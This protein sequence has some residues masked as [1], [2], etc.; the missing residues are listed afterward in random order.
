MRYTCSSFEIAVGPCL[1]TI[2]NNSGTGFPTCFLP[3]E[4][5][6]T[7]ASSGQPCCGSGWRQPRRWVAQPLAKSSRHT[8]AQILLHQQQH[9]HTCKTKTNNLLDRW[10]DSGW[11]YFLFIYLW[12]CVTWRNDSGRIDHLS[13]D[14]VD[15]GR[16]ASWPPERIREQRPGLM[17]KRMAK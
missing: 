12:S 14:I 2:Q 15:N 10:C 3:P 5:L 11:I 13:K 17:R 4:G 16:T 6:W 8:P 9:T 1:S 7:D